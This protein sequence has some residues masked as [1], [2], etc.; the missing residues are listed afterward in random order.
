M[1]GTFMYI[2]SSLNEYHVYCGIYDGGSGLIACKASPHVA[3][4]RGGHLSGRLPKT[5]SPV[6][7]WSS[8]KS[9]Q[10]GTLGDI[11]ALTQWGWGLINFSRPFLG[12]FSLWLPLPAL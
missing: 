10:P 8:G 4:M 12:A 7:C 6:E 9:S 1:H 5:P 3:R 11:A 2:S